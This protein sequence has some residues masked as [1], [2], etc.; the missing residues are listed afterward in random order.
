MDDYI[1]RPLKLVDK[2]KPNDPPFIINGQTFNFS[3]LS[4][5]SDEPSKKATPIKIKKV[6]ES[7]P[8]EEKESNSP[9][10]IEK[11]TEKI[12]QEELEN[13]KLKE[14]LR[15]DLEIQ[16]QERREKMK[17]REERLLSERIKIQA[18]REE[19]KRKQKERLFS[20]QVRQSYQSPVSPSPRVIDS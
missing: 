18:R 9:N 16:R 10:E 19:N 2:E 20:E 7:D 17:E 12:E 3:R 1:L 15:S 5:I 14:Q 13:Q 4:L 6:K 8:V 11:L